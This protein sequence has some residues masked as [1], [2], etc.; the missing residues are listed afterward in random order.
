MR[1]QER[2]QRQHVSQLQGRLLW[3]PQLHKYGT[4]LLF[5]RSSLCLCLQYRN[6]FDFHASQDH[7]N[8]LENMDFCNYKALTTRIRFHLKTQLFNSVFKKIRVH[9][10]S[11]SYRFRLEMVVWRQRFRKASFSSVH[12]KTVK[13][14][15]QKVRLWRAF[16]KSCV[17][18][19]RCHCTRVDDSRYP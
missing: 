15:F 14:R 5:V 11:Y 17:F 8:I 7:G 1:L 4:T 6:L 18:G 16:S 9:T 10:V 13:R 2:I 19:Y 12:T 3:I